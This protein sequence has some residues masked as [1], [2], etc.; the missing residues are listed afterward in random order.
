MNNQ[1]NITDA[2]WQIM[3]MI[4]AGN[5]TKS[6]DIIAYLGKSK[7]W[8]PTTIKTLLAR[9]VKKNVISFNLQDRTRLYY[10]LFTEMECV[11]NEMSNVIKRLYGGIVNHHTEH[12]TFY[13]HN[14]PDYISLLASTLEHDYQMILNILGMAKVE[15]IMVYTHETKLHLHSALGIQNGPE[16]LRAGWAWGILHIAPK[17]CFDDIK[18]ERA[19]VHIFSQIAIHRLNPGT[20]YWLMQGYSAYLSKWLNTDRIRKAVIEQ[21]SSQPQISLDD[22]GSDFEKFRDNNGYELAYT[23]VQFI[24]L[25][26]GAGHMSLFI[27]NPHDFEGIFNCTKERFQ[28]NWIRFLHKKYMRGIE[29]EN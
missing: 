19:A 1:S 14:D 17:E 29:Y 21:L 12:F 2:E 20:P 18:P 23:R 26:Y 6:A 9:L 8:S 10:P 4:W 15:K 24:I 11:R 16:W 13:G 25:E 5:E 7:G 28:K 3:R 27:K 22:I